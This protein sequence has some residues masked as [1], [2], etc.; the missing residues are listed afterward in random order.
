MNKLTFLGHARPL[1]VDMIME[2]R[3]VDVEGHLRTGIQ[4]GADAFGLQM[5]QLMPE[6]RDEK[7]LREL[8]SYLADRPLYLTNYRGGFNQGRLSDE[9]RMDELKMA[10]A[11]GATL[12]DLTTDTFAPSPFEVTYDAKA[13][14]RQR[15]IIDEFHALGAEVLMSSHVLEFRT[16]EEVLA[17]ALEQQRRGADI[18]KIVTFSGNEKE[19]E[20]NFA[21][22]SLLKRE[23]SAPFLFLSNGPYCK[24]H[25]VLGPYFGSCMWLCVDAYTELSS[26]N[27]PLLRS[28]VA[29]VRNIDCA[30]NRI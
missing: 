11:C 1:I 10:I 30:P 21:A 20:S 23:L 13:V 5:E 19:L 17:I 29:A 8:F 18:A 24:K 26:R 7:T 27:Q 3:P 9:Q 16:P 22:I 28:M 2:R 15:R 4:E 6:H 12:V 25:R 14:D